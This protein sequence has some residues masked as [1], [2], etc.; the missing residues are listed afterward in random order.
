MVMIWPSVISWATP[1]PATMMISVAMIGWM[2][3]RATRKPFH[4]PQ[5][6]AASSPMPMASSTADRALW[7]AWSLMYEQVRAPVMATTAPTERSMPPVAMTRV[8][9]TATRMSGEPNSTIET[10][11]P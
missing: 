2:P 6:T 9:P 8:M 11:L 7:S 5:T 3:I 1:R 4:R 10:R